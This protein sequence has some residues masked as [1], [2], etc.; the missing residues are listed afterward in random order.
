VRTDWAVIAR[1]AAQ[2]GV[3][4]REA[5]NRAPGADQGRGTCT[6]QPA[7]QRRPSRGA[8]V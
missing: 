1:P 6:D 8:R 2:S 4:R 5:A 7:C 3:R